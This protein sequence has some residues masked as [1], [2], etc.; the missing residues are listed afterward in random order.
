ML[1]ALCL[2]FGAVSAWAEVAV[3]PLNARVIDL[4]GTLDAA[5]KQGVE[6]KLAALEQAK[7]A[8][9]AVLVIAAT[10]PES[11]EQYALRVAEAWKLGRKG[12]DD[13]ALLLIAKDER[14]LRIEVGYGLEGAIPDAMAKRIIAE[15]IVPRFQVG[16][17]AG[18]VEAGVDALIK[19]VQGEPLPLPAK[20]RGGSLAELGDMLPAAM[21]FIFVL[22]GVLRMMLGRLA[23]AGV[24]AT[25]AFMGAWLL[26]GGVLIAL[27]VAVGAFV[28]VL[29][30]GVTG[31]RRRGG[32]GGGG[33]GGGIGGG[34]GGGG[35]FGGGGGGFGGGGASG[36]W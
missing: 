19:L 7:G 13:G 27:I 33:F 28:F 30:G 5:S 22:G 9:I 16:D 10:A 3:P 32:Y 4:T 35:G 29:A 18:G 25:V 20:S 17:F 6:G 12:V 23:G 2:L 1:F 24:A 11:I 8:Q 31:G 26:L 34:G 36:R 14:A 21:M 15:I